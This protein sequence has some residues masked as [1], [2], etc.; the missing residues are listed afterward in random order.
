MFFLATRALSAFNPLKNCIQ[1]LQEKL[2][3]TRVGF[4]S[5]NQTVKGMISD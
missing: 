2:V 4:F 5:L 3:G 1:V